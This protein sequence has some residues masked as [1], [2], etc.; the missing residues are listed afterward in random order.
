MK[1]LPKK[2]R[3]RE[4]LKIPPKKRRKSAS[5]EGVAGEKYGQEDFI[6]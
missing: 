3:K 2:R 5:A 1:G 6:E 4:A